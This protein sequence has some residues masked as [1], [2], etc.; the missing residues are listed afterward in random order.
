MDI[1]TGVMIVLTAYY[2]WAVNREFVERLKD[3]L[4]RHNSDPFTEGYRNEL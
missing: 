3:K 1:G 4:R 2:A